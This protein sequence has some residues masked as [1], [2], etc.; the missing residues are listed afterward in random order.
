M[1]PGERSLPKQ[2]RPH[3][4]NNASQPCFEATKDHYGIATVKLSNTAASS[5]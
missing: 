5:G 2:V 1:K 3:S 4:T